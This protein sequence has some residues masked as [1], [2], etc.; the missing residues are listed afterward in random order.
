MEEEIKKRVPNSEELIK[1]DKD[2]LLEYFNK[3]VDEFVKIE[4]VLPSEISLVAEGYSQ[5]SFWKHTVK[6]LLFQIP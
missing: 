5:K 2:I 1:M 6:R 4:G 3:T